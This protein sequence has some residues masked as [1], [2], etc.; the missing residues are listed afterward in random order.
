LIHGASGYWLRWLLAALTPRPAQK[1][2]HRSF[3]QGHVQVNAGK[4]DIEVF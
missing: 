4:A 2:L 1:Y 3:C